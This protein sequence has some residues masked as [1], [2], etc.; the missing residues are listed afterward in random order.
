MMAR[1]PLF[2]WLGKMLRANLPT[3]VQPTPLVS[4]DK[5]AQTEPILSSTPISRRD[6][7]KA[8][9]GVAGAMISWSLMDP[10]SWA[11]AGKL[12]PT[13]NSLHAKSNSIA[14]IGGGLGGL[15]TAYRLHHQGIRC[16]LYEASHRLGGRVF[17]RNHFNTEGMFVEL[18]GELVD[19]GHEDLIALCQEL[20]VPLEHFV[21]H[22]LGIE[23]AIFYSDG[24]IHTEAQ[25]IEAFQGLAQV[26]AADL[27]RC[28]PDGNIVVPTY[29]QPAN[30]AWLDQRSLAEYLEQLRSVA[31]DWLLRIIRAAYIGEYGLDAE[32]QS[33]LN[34]PL[35]IA[36]DTAEG[37]RI[38][39]DSDE[40]M[41]IQGGNSRL[42]E[43]LVRAIKPHVPIHYGH[44]LTR[45]AL[46]NGPLPGADS[47][48]VQS[49]SDTR[50]K[51]GFSVG[52][53]FRWVNVSHAVMALPFTVLR[54]VNGVDRIGLSPVKLRSIREM[55]YGT[56]SKQMIGFK[57]R[58]WRADHPQAAANTPANSGE[59]FTDLPT[60]CYW[61]TSR[62]Q[63]GKSGIL[64]NF[65][66]GR[67]GKEA[68]NSHWEIVL[69]DLKPL[70][71]DL[72]RQL[73]GHTAFFNWHNHPWSRGS[74]SCPRPGQYTSIWG[75]AHLPELDGRL[76]FA[77]E[78]CSLN[79]GGFMNGAVESG[80]TAA[81]QISEK[82]AQTAVSTVLSTVA[83]A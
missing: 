48:V 19:T 5:P 11:E 42:V 17:T 83:Q 70:F 15:V 23:P 62:L 60:Q 54:D 63:P 65:T 2:R 43:A 39:G 57:S 38:F 26:L 49:H 4:P 35:L 27:N 58:F 36:T 20:H 69:Q 29:L 76:F 28:F 50:L 73:D 33:A 1:T 44:R 13:A 34:L 81:R 21:Q 67:A 68:T 71:G 41:R 75:T 55:G 6:F 8:T 52:R 3:S 74:Y 79:S 32:E 72:H 24:A 10:V 37:L 14:I 16:E 59:L 30:A 47:K 64:T 31:P 18:G 51:L 53:Q 22:E 56:N 61:D 12:L 66:G 77:G 82:L 80:N 7:L 78:H 46:P 9:A 45:L 40:C 25:V